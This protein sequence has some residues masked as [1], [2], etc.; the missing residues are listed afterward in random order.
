MMAAKK[1][2]VEVS[3]SEIW[4]ALFGK[5]SRWLIRF[6]DCI[7]FCDSEYAIDRS[8]EAYDRD[9]MDG[10]TALYERRNER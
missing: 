10:L 4:Q 3:E 9:G 8:I 5:P 7:W 2:P 1:Y 6:P